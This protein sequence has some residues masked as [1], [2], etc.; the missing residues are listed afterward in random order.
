MRSDN[1]GTR[2]G[3]VWGAFLCVLVVAL[4]SRFLADWGQPLFSHHDIRQTQT[5]LTIYWFVRE[6]IDF[7]NPA[8]P[9]FGP[10]VPSISPD[11]PLFQAV[12]ALLLKLT[13]GTSVDAV[14]V[15]ARAVNFAFFLLASF[16]LFRVLR[17]QF[18]ASTAH[19]VTALWLLMP[20]AWFWSFAV[21]IEFMAL[22]FTLLFFAEVYFL[23]TSSDRFRRHLWG[24]CAFGILAALVKVTTFSVMVPSAALIYLVNRNLHRTRRLARRDIDAALVAFVIPLLAGAAWMLWTSH[25]R[26]QN[27]YQAD[28]LDSS[29]YLQWAFGSLEQR[30]SLDTWYQILGYVTGFEILGLVGIP[31]FLIGVFLSFSRVHLFAWLL[32]LPVAVLV[33]TNLYFRHDYYQ[34]A[35]VAGIAVVTC[36]GLEAACRLAV[37]RFPTL[38]RFA[39]AGMLTLGGCVLISATTW[40]V[41]L[42]PKNA[43]ALIRGDD[44][45]PSYAYTIQPFIELPENSIL[46]AARIVKENSSPDQTILVRGRG[47]WT[48]LPLYAER[49]VLLTAWA[50]AERK[51]RIAR[52]VPIGLFVDFDEQDSCFLARDENCVVRKTD[53]YWI[54]RCYRDLLAE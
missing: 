12:V 4:A 54:G 40:L 30:L 46:E 17:A 39:G 42:P 28:V 19:A 50:C 22:A 3:E 53:D 15:A 38:S 8:L 24:A 14:E 33:F 18:Q 11:F 47:Q 35:V 32:P 34:V 49:K 21:M 36:A 43:L 9:I 20:F 44:M 29:F 23:S 52:Q 26:G 45:R 16:A 13:G 31:F 2:G 41:H 27:V 37:D 6:G 51:W 10:G 25:T 1:I 5:A 7:L 48:Q